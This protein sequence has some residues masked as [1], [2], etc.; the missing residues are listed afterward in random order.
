MYENV[1]QGYGKHSRKRD[2][3]PQPISIKYIVAIDTEEKYCFQ[4]RNC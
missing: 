4:R 3:M 2:S 1:Q